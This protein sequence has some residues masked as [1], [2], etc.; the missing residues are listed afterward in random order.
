M[1]AKSQKR[2]KLLDGLLIKKYRKRRWFSCG[3]R[4]RTVWCALDR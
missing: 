2:L 1:V 3:E 4:R